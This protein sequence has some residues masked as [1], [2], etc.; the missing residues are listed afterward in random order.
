VTA[1]PFA[2]RYSVLDEPNRAFEW[3]ERA[4]ADRDPM[5]LTLNVDSAFDGLRIRRRS[6]AYTN[7]SLLRHLRHTALSDKS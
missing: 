7:R 3:L 2:T 1:Y 5:L 4:F 6:S